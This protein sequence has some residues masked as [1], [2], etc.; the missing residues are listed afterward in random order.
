MPDLHNHTPYCHHAF[1]EPREYFAR[2]C[3]L[4][5]REFG[6]SEHSPW[7]HQ[8]EGEPLAPTVAGF[9]RCLDELVALR[10]DAAGDT[11][12]RIGIEM[13]YLPGAREAA[14]EFTS[15]FP[16]DYHIGSVHNLGPWIFDHPDRLG[17]WNS[18]DVDAVYHEYFAAVADLL[19][20]GFVDILGHL[21]LPKKFGHRP[22]GGCLPLIEELIPRIV[23]SGA[24]VE[25]NTAGRDKPVGEFYPAPD[26]VRRLAKA[27]VGFTIG[28]DAHRPSEVGRHRADAVALL[29]ECGVRD[30]YTF[31]QR[32]AVALPLR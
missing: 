8:Y 20:W 6:F 31:D 26:I 23:E 22:R 19:E 29:R 27:G 16:F 28:S 3:Q 30:I 9:R 32:R 15:S 14:R 7:M 12:L 17:E 1:G 10:A 18:R 4:G 5:L 24:V 2:A 25:I 13:D 11:K 21:D